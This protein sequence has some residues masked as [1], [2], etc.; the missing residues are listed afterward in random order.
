MNR[1]ATERLIAISVGIGKLAVQS[2][3]LY[4]ISGEVFD[5]E[6][7]TLEAVLTSIAIRF[8]LV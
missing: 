3:C 4:Y 5:H 1:E 2:V 8:F 6:I 7:T